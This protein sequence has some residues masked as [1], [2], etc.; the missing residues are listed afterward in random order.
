MVSLPQSSQWYETDQFWESHHV[1]CCKISATGVL[2]GPNGKVKTCA[3]PANTRTLLAASMLASGSWPWICE[4]LV[5]VSPKLGILESNHTVDF[6]TTITL[7]EKHILLSLTTVTTVLSKK[8]ISLCQSSGNSFRACN[9]VE[10]GNFRGFSIPLLSQETCIV[11]L[12]KKLKWPHPGFW[13]QTPWL[14]SMKH[15]ISK[16]RILMSI[17]ISKLS[18]IPKCQFFLP[19]PYRSC[20]VQL[21][22]SVLYSKLVHQLCFTHSSWQSNA[23]AANLSFD[24]FN[25]SWFFLTWS[26]NLS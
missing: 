23:L 12:A 20:K 9:G 24:S 8:T 1:S 22:V 3:G 19:P 6:P 5:N 4:C 18:N 17:I 16:A 7:W 26:I 10:A 21:L 13:L 15:K 11:D 25:D 2:S 14:E